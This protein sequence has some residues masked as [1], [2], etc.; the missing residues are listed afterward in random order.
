MPAVLG[1]C[2]DKLVGCFRVYLVIC[3]R[4]DNTF[5]LLP[6]AKNVL[7]HITVKFLKGYRKKLQEVHARV[8]MCVYIGN[9][10]IIS[11]YGFLRLR[12]HPILRRIR[13]EQSTR[14]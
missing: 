5:E 4:N 13:S 9:L 8:C 11:F 14:M 10:G 7:T 1:L 2:F 3:L 6:K 12:L